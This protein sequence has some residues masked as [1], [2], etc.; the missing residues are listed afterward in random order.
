MADF[1]SVPTWVEPE[2]PEYHTL[3]TEAE[4]MKKRFQSLSAS[5]VEKFKL[6]FTGVS[7][8]TYATIKTHFDGQLGG[9]DEFT[10]KSVP[11]YID[12]GANKT[13]RW[14]EGSFKQT[15]RAKGW[16]LELTFEESV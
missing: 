9:Y 10:W 15:P 5:P 3:V 2:S 4:S 12:A 16:D 7:D 13:G 14:V 8:T 11:S 1:T 6:T